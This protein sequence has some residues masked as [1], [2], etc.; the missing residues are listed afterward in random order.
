[1]YSECLMTTNNDLNQLYFPI[2]LSTVNLINTYA[3]LNVF[4]PYLNHRNG[5][6]G[7]QP[8][9]NHSYRLRNNGYDILAIRQF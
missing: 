4:K 9:Y 3:Q 8:T 1:M 5:E 6:R 7:R 2:G